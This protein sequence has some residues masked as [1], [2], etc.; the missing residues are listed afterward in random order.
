MAERLAGGRYVEVE[1]ERLAAARY[2]LNIADVQT[3]VSGAIGGANVART[4]E[5]LARYPINVRYPREI[6][7]SV[8]ELRA[9]PVLTPSGQQITLGT[10][11]RIAV[12]DGAPMLKSEQ[13]DR[14]SVV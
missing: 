12:S 11:A 10:V 3:I 5:G 4:V 13:G 9:L 7:D 8:D 6:R 1:I 14:K 2:G